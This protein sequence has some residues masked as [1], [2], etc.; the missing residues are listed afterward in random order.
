MSFTTSDKDYMICHFLWNSI[1]KSEA[2]NVDYQVLDNRAASKNCD[3]SSVS[4][5]LTVVPN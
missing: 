5:F 1:L 4:A 3:S 2:Y